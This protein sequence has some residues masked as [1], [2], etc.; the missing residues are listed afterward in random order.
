MQVN[1]STYDT[2]WIHVR[3]CVANSLRVDLFQQIKSETP[4]KLSLS[5]LCLSHSIISFCHKSGRS[6]D[7]SPLS[8]HLSTP[9]QGDMQVAVFVDFIEEECHLHILVLSQIHYLNIV[10][11]L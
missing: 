8:L 2:F 11:V 1:T 5:P 4:A 7:F 9:L 6:W 3:I 10:Q